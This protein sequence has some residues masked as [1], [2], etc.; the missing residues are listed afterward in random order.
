MIFITLFW[1]VFLAILIFELR[2]LSRSKK[3]KQDRG[4][5]VFILV[6]I[7]LPIVIVLL[8]NYFKFGIIDKI[9]IRYLGLG[10]LIFGFILRQW[11]ILILGRFFVPV[12]KLQKNQKVIDKGPYKYL[13]H[14]SYTGLLFELIGF[15]LGLSNLTGL[16]F[17]LALFLPTII[18]RIRVEE[19]F[20]SQHLAGY[21]EYTAK[22]WRLIP[23]IY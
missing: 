2:I 20:L 5:M 11:A 12:V 18:Y 23:L 15:S 13:R 14:P 7:F 22:T 8:L 10:V 19:K 9:F 17:V 21:S 3:S 1:I 16:F 6:G 4:S